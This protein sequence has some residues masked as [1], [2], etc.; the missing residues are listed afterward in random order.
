[1]KKILFIIVLF[2]SLGCVTVRADEQAKIPQIRSISSV[3]YRDGICF[4]FPGRE[5]VGNSVLLPS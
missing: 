3:S 5:M 1:M 2:A 4:T